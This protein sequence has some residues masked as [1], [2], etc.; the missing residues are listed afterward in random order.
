MTISINFNTVNIMKLLQENYVRHGLMMC[1][2][3]LFCLGL[4]ELTGNNESFDSKSP[5]TIVFMFIAPFVI[6]YMG[7]NEKKK[8]LKGKLTFKKGVMEGLK[9]S[10][11]FAIISPFIFMLYYLLLNPDILDYVRTAYG[12][13]E[14]PDAIVI[15]VDM[16]T[17]FLS[18]IVFGTIYAVI[19]TFL[20]LKFSKK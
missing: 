7:I 13:R 6:W 4:M 12:L 19:I 10:L 16:L 1:G 17:Q 5:I 15:T 3:L 2:V 9:I 18:A 8:M 11:T 14:L 20:I